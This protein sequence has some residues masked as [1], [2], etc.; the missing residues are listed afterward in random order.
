M[1]ADL[2]VQPTIANGKVT[3]WKLCHNKPTNADCGFGSTQSPYPVVKFDRDSGDHHITINIINGN[4]IKFAPTNPIWI[5]PDIKPTA[6]VVAPTDQIDP[7]KISPGGG[8]ELKFHDANKGGPITLKYQLNFVDANGAAVT[9]LDPEILNGGKGKFVL[10]QAA[11]FLI[12]GSVLLALAAI[13][14]ATARRR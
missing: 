8:T 6:A 14:F 12:A 11:V 10:S 1:K 5:Q 13:W 9:A 4:G 2:I 3:S 7:S